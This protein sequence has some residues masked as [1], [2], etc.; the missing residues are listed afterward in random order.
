MH[1]VT[2]TNITYEPQNSSLPDALTFE[3]DEAVDHEYLNI[4]LKSHIQEH[5]Q[6]SFN[7]ASEVVSFDFSVE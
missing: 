2:I 4:E 3:F 7:S 1:T 5:I 6:E